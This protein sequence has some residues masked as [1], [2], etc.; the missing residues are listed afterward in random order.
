MIRS[1][2]L[3]Y[4]LAAS[5]LT[6]L[7]AGPACAAKNS[8]SA[9]PKASLTFWHCWADHQSFLD[10][11]AERY[12]LKTGVK[13]DFQLTPPMSRNYW[14]KI[15]TAAQANTLPDIIGIL[16]NPELIS[17]YA[18]SGRLAELTREMTADNRAWANSFYP[19]ALNALYY[20]KHNLYGVK[21]ESYWGVPLTVMNIQ[22]FYN[23]TL[24]QK[25]G[26]NPDR[27]PQTWEEFISA[28]HALRMA[29]ITP[30]IAGF[31]DLWVSQSFFRAYSW[32]VLGR[33]K[34]R[35]LYLDEFPYMAPECQQIM[36]YFAELRNKGLLYPGAASMA[37]KEAEILFAN[38]KAAMM[39]N[40]S[41]GANVYAQ[42]NPRLDLGVMPYPK[43]KDAR[44]PMY[45]LGSLDQGA[46]VT[47]HSKNAKNAIAFLKWLTAQPQQ[48]RWARMPNGFPALLKAQDQIDSKLQ[49]FAEDMRNLPPNLFLEERQDVLETL[50]KSMQALL[51][52]EV[53]PLE[54][55]REVQRIKQEKPQRNP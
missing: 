21:S 37:N 35:S 19:H 40:D 43:P 42:M 3:R 8:K 47:A 27:P 26:L 46:V 34:I 7:I 22:I 44:C 2:V 54:A 45:S 15:E 25:A 23:R 13:I 16:E 11:M 29:G 32:A 55:L 33:D 50:G 53:E 48:E 1:R 51:I 31:G 17:R 9:K 20:P 14:N 30:L 5:L 6:G 49:P 39:I 36:N 28:S 24:F 38:G 52:G 12:R 18:K 4:A 10:E 41:R